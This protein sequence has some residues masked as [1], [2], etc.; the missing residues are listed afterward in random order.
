MVFLKKICSINHPTYYLVSYYGSQVQW[1]NCNLLDY[2]SRFGHYKS[3][4]IA[5]QTNPK[6]RAVTTLLKLRLLVTIIQT[7]GVTVTG[8]DISASPPSPISAVFSLIKSQKCFSNA[9]AL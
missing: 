1:Q 7:Q 6:L 4:L 8:L 3:G 5:I 9:C 2:I